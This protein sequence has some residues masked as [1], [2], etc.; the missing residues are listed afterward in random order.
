M[1]VILT[2]TTVSYTIRWWWWV[3]IIRALPSVQEFL[4]KSAVV[5]DIMFIICSAHGCRFQIPSPWYSE[6]LS[7]YPACRLVVSMYSVVKSQPLILDMF[8]D[9][10]DCSPYFLFESHLFTFLHMFFLVLTAKSYVRSII[11]AS[12]QPFRRWWDRRAARQ[13]MYPLVIKH[14]KRKFPIPRGFSQ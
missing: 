1:M 10:E 12:R 7:L 13:D 8:L 4:S 2:Y 14:A 9:Q 5:N 6:G 11:L 3:E